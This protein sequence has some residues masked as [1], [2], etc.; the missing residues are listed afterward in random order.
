MAYFFGKNI[1][2]NSTVFNSFSD[3]VENLILNKIRLKNSE[4]EKN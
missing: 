1:L 2:H 3:S 4:T